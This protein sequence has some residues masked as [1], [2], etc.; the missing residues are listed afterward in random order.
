MQ[1]KAAWIEIFRETFE[2]LRPGRDWTHFVE[3]NEAI[4]PILSGLNAEQASRKLRP[5]VSSIAAHARHTAY[6]IEMLN[7]TV[8]GD[9]G[10]ADWEGSWSV[11]QV[12][13]SQWLSIQADLKLQYEALLN[14]LDTSTAE[15][16]DHEQFCVIMAQLAHAAFHLG[17]IRQLS[18][19][20]EPI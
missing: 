17:T 6:Y 20:V 11:Q 5:D 9:G 10:A 18:K 14:F 2:G 16:K 15:P 8:A 3:G 4:L 7:R 12:N 19:L 1:W 13:P